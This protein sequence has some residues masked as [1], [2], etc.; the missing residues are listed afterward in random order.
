MTPYQ[1]HLAELRRRD[2]F[3]A[4]ASLLYLAAV[5]CLCWWLT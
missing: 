1:K 3:E 5:A 2:A 4:A